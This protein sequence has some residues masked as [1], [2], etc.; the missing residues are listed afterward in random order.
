MYKQRFTLSVV[1]FLVISV[2]AFSSADYMSR[3]EKKNIVE[4]AVAAGKFNTLVTAVKAADLVETLSGP[5]PF[6]VF[7]PTD[8]AFAKLPE[9][10]VESL[11]QNIPK[12]K[13]ILTY[14][15]V[16]GKVMASDV[17]NL[18]SAATVNGQQI[19]IK[20]KDGTVMVDNA[21]VVMTDIECTNG[22]IH[23]IDSVILPK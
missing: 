6:T 10:T 14:H 17:V 15:V 13:A 5:G 4:T 8:D 18:Q 9:G 12:L 22:V 16:A 19:T 1:A 11:L 7:A 21:K 20:V 3:M 2:L 23:I